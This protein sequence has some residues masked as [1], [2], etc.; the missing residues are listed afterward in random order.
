MDEVRITREGPVAL[1]T[2]DRPERRNALTFD[3]YRFLRDTFNELSQDRSVRAVVLGAAGEAFCSGGDVRDIIGATLEQD[4][5]ARREF[6]DLTCDLIQS[7]RDCQAPV[8]AA[9]PGLA[10]GAGAVMALACDLRVACPDARIAFLFQKVGLSGADMG[11]AQLLPRAVGLSRASEILLLADWVSAEDAYSWGLYHRLVP[12]E[13]VRTTALALAERLA[14][15]S[16]DALAETKRCLEAE[17]PLDLTAAL[18][19]ESE[20]QAR[21]MGRGPYREGFTAFT[22]KREPDFPGSEEDARA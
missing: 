11:A 8:V 21:L 10:C 15:F 20:T 9:L 5:A 3:S 14:G 19:I 1:V 22:E 13:D 2:L 17:H 16:R 4:E 6:T 18:E 7:I 12:R